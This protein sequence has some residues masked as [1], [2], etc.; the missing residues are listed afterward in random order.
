MTDPWVAFGALVALVFIPTLLTTLMY[1]VDTGHAKP[2]VM[3]LLFPLFLPHLLLKIWRLWWKSL[4][5]AA[6][7]D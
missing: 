4:R 6:T 7:E 3:T 1:F 5:E 2:F